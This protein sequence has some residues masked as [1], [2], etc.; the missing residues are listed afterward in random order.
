MNPKY[1]DMYEYHSHYQI[2]CN[3]CNVIIKPLKTIKNEKN[4]HYKCWIKE[5]RKPITQ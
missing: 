2:I 4:Y 3:Y 5:C 1:P